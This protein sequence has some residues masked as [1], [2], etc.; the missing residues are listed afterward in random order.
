MMT[1]LHSKAG[2]KATTSKACTRWK[3]SAAL[4]GAK[5]ARITTAIRA[6]ITPI[7]RQRQQ[8]VRLQ[9]AKRGASWITS[10][11]NS[12]SK[13]C[14]RL[15]AAQG[16]SITTPAPA[17]SGKQMSPPPQQRMPRCQQLRLPTLIQRRPR[18]PPPPPQ[19]QQQQHQS[20]SQ[21]H[22]R[23]QKHQ[24]QNRRRRWCRK[25]LGQR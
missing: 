25:R 18:S 9:R 12:R 14:A 19:Q 3:I 13:S 20:P 16:A 11:G 5:D 15:Q 4:H 24:P 17:Q 10:L 22:P 2:A 1:P 21:Q 6:Q 23:Q 8:Q 7:L